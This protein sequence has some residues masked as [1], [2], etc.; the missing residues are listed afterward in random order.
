VGYAAIYIPEFPSLAWLRLEPSARPRAIAVVEGSAPLERIVSF[1]R[2][3][4][5]LGLEHG[6]SKVQADTSG[7]ILFHE[8]A[9]QGFFETESFPDHPGR[10][11]DRFGATIRLN[12]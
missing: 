1:N 4:K 5:E 9:L 10:S 3:S 2:A 12:Q 11:E 6:M 8:L 7:Q